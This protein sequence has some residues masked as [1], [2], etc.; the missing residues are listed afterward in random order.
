PDL[1]LGAPQATD[2]EAVDPDQLT[3]PG[4]VDVALGA[5]IARWLVGRRVAGHQPQALGARVEA[6]AA[7]HLPDAVG[8][9]DDGAPLVACQLRGDALGPESGVCDR[10]AEDPLLD[11]LRQLVGHLG[12]TALPGAQHLQAVAVDRPLPG[13]VGRAMHPEAPAGLRDACPGGL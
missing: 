5:G 2:V 6:V 11:H 7:E 1:A 3:G 10:E 12:A 13:V 4:D 8:G 9:D